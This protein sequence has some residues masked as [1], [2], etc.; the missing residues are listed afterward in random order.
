M[1]GQTVAKVFFFQAEDGIRDAQESRG[2]GDV[3]KRQTLSVL[4]PPRVRDTVLPDLVVDDPLADPQHG[5]CFLLYPVVLA[6]RVEDHFTLGQCQR[7]H[8]L[9]VITVVVGRGRL[10]LG[11]ARMEDGDVLWFHQFAICKQHGTLDA[12]PDL[13]DIGRP[14]MVYD[15][16]EGLVAAAPP[17]LGGRPPVFP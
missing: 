5:C 1:T 4:D 10:S 6:Q 2:L 15:R 17:G 12:V 7:G 14:V 16:L 13:V 11:G 3:Y 8:G 9:F